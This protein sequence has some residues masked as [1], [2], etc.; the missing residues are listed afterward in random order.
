MSP[1]MPAVGDVDQPR[2][3][4]LNREAGRRLVR[5]LRPHAGTI[6]V[7]V[8]LTVVLT[9]VSLSVPRLLGWT[10][11]KAVDAVREARLLAP[12]AG[13][14]LKADAWREVARVL[15]A[16]ALLF[17]ASEVVRHYE[18]RRVII[19]SQTFM[20]NLRQRFF[21]HLHDLSARYYDKMKAGQIIARGTTDVETLQHTVSWA[22]NHLTSAFLTLAGAVGMMLWM[23]WVLFL[24][25]FP[26]L[27]AL[28]FLTR[29]FRLR[30]T[31]AWREVRQQ[32]GRLT[33][34]VAESIAGA[35]VIQAFAR[36][37]K[38]EQAFSE[39]TTELYD[40]RVETERVRGR[41][42]MGM[43]FLQAMAPAVVIVL[44][45]WRVASTAAGPG[46]GPET[47]AR[48]VTAGDVVAFLGYVYMF[49]F[50]ME[51]IS[52]LYNQLLHA[53]A[54]A[55]RI[56]DVFDAEPEIVD[57]PDAL[58]PDDLDGRVTFDHVRFE[59]VEGTP[60]LED[61]SFEATPGEAIALVGPTGAGKTTLCRLI[62][63]FY[64]AGEGTVRIDGHDVRTIQQTAL[65]RRMGIVLQENFLFAG[66]VMD[67]IRYGRPEATDEEVVA[68]AERLGSHFAI[69][70]LPKGYETEV[71]ERGESLSAGQ[72]QL[73]CFTRAMLADPRVLI[74]DEATSSID[75]QTELKIQEAL[76]RLTERRTCFIV[77][78][79]LST[80]RRADRV[81]V[82]EGGRITE[83]GT[84]RELMSAGG[85]YARMYEEFIRSE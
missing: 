72:R 74:L 81:L 76:R 60:V 69:E 11:D 4:R 66:T 64:E 57:G 37:E 67:N 48:A 7:N 2:P 41:Y 8:L 32:T 24:A 27:P 47:A 79:R 55:E 14:A 5:W 25:V 78:H 70:A 19:F 10:I 82:I 49:F 36:E 6:L 58:R 63:R 15:G 83:R 26:M 68:C 9:A 20:C 50:P 38:N 80:V 61:V 1:Q 56:I 18:I 23:D 46:A 17:V 3:T 77:A 53:L 45:A 28:F 39:L 43:H 62:G 13:Q 73:I 22:P 34:N 42:M 75:T 21:R 44:G 65:H 71:G 33:A 52:E 12:A 40:T 30:A 54:A 29:W 16:F 85:R 84:H 31:A 51:M 35:R 59:Y